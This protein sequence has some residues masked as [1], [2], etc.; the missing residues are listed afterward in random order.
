[1][2]TLNNGYPLPEVKKIIKFAKL[3]L[4]ININ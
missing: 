4:V 1:M 2:F 3:K